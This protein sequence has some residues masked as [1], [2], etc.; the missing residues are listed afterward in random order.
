MAVKH[1]PRKETSIPSKSRK[2]PLTDDLPSRS[3]GGTDEQSCVN[4]GVELTHELVRIKEYDILV[5]LEKCQYEEVIERVKRKNEQEVLGRILI[6]NPD[7]NMRK[8]AAWVLGE[9]GQ[10]REHADSAIVQLSNNLKDA[11]AHVRST[12]NTAL[13]TVITEERQ[14]DM[15]KDEIID[16]LLALDRGSYNHDRRYEIALM[17]CSLSNKGI[18]ISP[19]IRNILEDLTDDAT[20]LYSFHPIAIDVLGYMSRMDG[21]GILDIMTEQVTQFVQSEWFD[22]ESQ[23]NSVEYVRVAKTLAD[24]MDTVK[25]NYKQVA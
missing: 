17:L 19:I 9:V 5:L 12:V 7:L 3:L 25:I 14:L 8:G 15:I 10:S 6:R 20:G 16:A 21:L 23:I 13:I 1:K 2:E 24:I 4:L 22:R 11:D 18:N